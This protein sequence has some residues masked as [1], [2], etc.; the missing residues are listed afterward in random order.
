ME[1]Y[2]TR[3]VGADTVWLTR[4]APWIAW[5]PREQ[6]K[7]FTTKA[8]ALAVLRRLRTHRGRLKV[9]AAEAA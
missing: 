1:F 3:A 5:G 4:D 6:A 7:K 8:A 9:I 2:V